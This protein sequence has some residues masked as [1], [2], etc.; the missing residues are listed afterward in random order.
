[1]PSLESFLN[2]Y[3]ALESRIRAVMLRLFSETCGMCT[4]CCC[5]VDICEEA[6]QSAFLSLLLSKQGLSA[7]DMDDRFGWLDLHGCSLKVGRP[8]ICY[9][10]FC[11]ELL[12]RL[13]DD[14]SRWVTK[15]LGRLIDYVG[16]DAANGVH[17][18]EISSPSDLE[19][20]D[21]TILT[22]RLTHACTAFDV[23]EQY[24]ETGML[25]PSDKELL[26]AFDGSDP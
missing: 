21:I 15:I 14:Q 9:A 3:A 23:I 10:F 11:D 5:R 17:L 12:A 7:S 6:H 13:P 24:V 4:A 26:S 19:R 18:V 2:D 22:D 20:L 8:P 16:E 1:M 25:A